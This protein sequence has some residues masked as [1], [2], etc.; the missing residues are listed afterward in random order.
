MSVVKGDPTRRPNRQLRRT[1]ADR[2]LFQATP[3]CAV[4]PRHARALPVRGSAAHDP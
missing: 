4:R 1:I 3:T 2:Q